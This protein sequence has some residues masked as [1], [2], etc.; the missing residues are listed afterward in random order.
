MKR[1]HIVMLLCLLLIFSFVNVVNALD[2]LKFSVSANASSTNVT[3]GEKVTISVA[4]KSDSAIANCTFSL[5][6]DDTL[7]YVSM[8]GANG[9]NVGSGGM[10]ANGFILENSSTDNIPLSDGKTVMQIVYNVNGSGKITISTKDCAS[11][12]EEGTDENGNPTEISGSYEDVVVNIEAVEPKDDTTLS[13]LKVTGGELIPE[14]IS[15][16]FSYQIELDSSTFSLDI[17]ANNSDYQDKIVVVD[18]NGNKL[19]SNS[20]T[21]SNDGGQGYMYM[22][23]IV[24]D[25]TS[26]P[27]EL[28]AHYEQNTLDNSLSSLKI[29]NEVVEL[30]DGQTDYTIKVS[31]DVT[32]VNVQAILKDT[33]NFGFREGN[34]PGTFKIADG[35]TS[36]ALVVVPNNS[37][38]GA[39]SKTYIIEIVR[40]GVPGNSSSF[41]SNNNANNNTTTNPSTGGVS[42]FLMAVILISSLIGSVILYQK[43]LEGYK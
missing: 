15:N 25:D 30:K 35:T 28:V 4:L 21:Y 23:I 43:N 19:D 31:K 22:K 38:I 24:N 9:W 26:S 36:I 2:V 1:K 6:S 34:E 14:F 27:Y 40:E 8:S 33:T 16:R 11:L 42:M 5:S 18:V 41:N 17:V 37:E 29:N 12:M 13:S 10:G 3:K 20:I 32:E 7:E 39:T